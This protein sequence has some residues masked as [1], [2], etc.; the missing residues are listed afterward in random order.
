MRPEL[1]TQGPVVEMERS[2]RT[3]IGVVSTDPLRVVGLKTILEEGDETA[4]MVEVI[5]LSQP[6]ALQTDGLE[7]VLIDAGATEFLLQLIMGFRRDRPKLRLLVLGPASD[8]HF[9]EQVIVAG[10]RGFLSY[11]ASESEIKQAIVVVEQ[12]SVWASR[13]VLANLLDHPREGLHAVLREAPK[14]TRRERQVLHLLTQG[15]PNR[16]IGQALGVDEGTVK[17][18]VGRLMRKVGVVNRTALT[19]LS[20]ERHLC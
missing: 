20:L 10:A 1:H 17:A 5:A 11:T 7:V 2:K 9:V 18:H 16:D 3:R 8:D 15:F 12:G 13:S 4:G 14:F 6:S 19:M